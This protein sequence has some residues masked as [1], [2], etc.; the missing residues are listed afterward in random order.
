[1]QE[2]IL[3]S[4]DN[5]IKNCIINYK[6]L[7]R[8]PFTMYSLHLGVYEHTFYRFILKRICK[9]GMTRCLVNKKMNLQD[10]LNEQ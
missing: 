9:E 8:N 10:T 2:K 5:L 7:F 4:F 6:I 1:M 3:F